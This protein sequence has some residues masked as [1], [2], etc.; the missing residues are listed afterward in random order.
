MAR[1]PVSVGVPPPS[2]RYA[3]FDRALAA[4]FVDGQCRA[5]YNSGRLHLAPDLVFPG[6]Y[7]HCERETG[8][9]VH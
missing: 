5:L 9:G 3:H 4:A 8:V 1:L 6:P 7:F 2:P